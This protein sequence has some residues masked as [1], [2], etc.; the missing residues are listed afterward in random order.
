MRQRPGMKLMLRVFDWAFDVVTAA[1]C[2]AV[3]LLFVLI[4]FGDAALSAEVNWGQE[5]SSLP[6]GSCGPLCLTSVGCSLGTLTPTC[7]SPVL[8]S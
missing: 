3:V 2:F 7:S 4:I 5:I 6:G 8:P 1:V